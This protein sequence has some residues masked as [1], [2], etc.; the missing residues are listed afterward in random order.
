MTWVTT[1]ELHF[2][3]IDHPEI[4]RDHRLQDLIRKDADILASIF[5]RDIKV[6]SFHN[7][8]P[9]GRYSV[10]V[11]GLINTYADKY[12][13]K[14]YYTSDS[15]VC[16]NSGCPCQVLRD[17]HHEVVQLL[18]HPNAFPANFTTDREVLLHFIGQKVDDLLTYN[19][20]NNRVLQA[21]GLP[22]TDA[23]EWIKTMDTSL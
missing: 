15:N 5:A 18:I 21:S 20:H 17:A 10:P 1:S 3:L 12:F 22:L 23:L 7:P 6:F 16:W 13:R 4:N 9:D 11:S 14:A 2:S 8:P 19:V